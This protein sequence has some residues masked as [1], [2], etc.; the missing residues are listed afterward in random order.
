[1]TERKEGE[2]ERRILALEAQQGK[3]VKRA[4]FMHILRKFD[5]DAKTTTEHCLLTPTQCLFLVVEEMRKDLVSAKTYPSV[6]KKLKHW[7]G[8]LELTT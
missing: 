6:R 2:L 4:D 5:P 3:I 8:S 1:M 7:L